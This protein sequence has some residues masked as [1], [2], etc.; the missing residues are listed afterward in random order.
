MAIASLYALCSK[1]Q[2]ISIRNSYSLIEKTI[3][4][5]L[6]DFIFQVL[7][8]NQP[9]NYTLDLHLPFLSHQQEIL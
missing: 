8:G 3:H 7:Y 2:S 5:K 9:Q 6:L 4:S 1:V